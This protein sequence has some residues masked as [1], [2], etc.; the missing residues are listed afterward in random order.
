MGGDPA[1]G[2]HQVKDGHRF[3]VN[4]SGESNPYDW[5]NA[6]FNVS[7]KLQVL[8]THANVADA[9]QMGIVNSAYSL[10]KKLNVKMDGIDVYDC[11]DVN[12]AINIKNLMEYS[13]GYSSSQGTNEFYYID[14]SRVAESKNLQ[15]MPLPL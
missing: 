4:N 3:S 1:D 11:S 10:I 15:S 2:E 13:T 14:K 6:R 7:F 9:D 8:A 5:Y 12:H